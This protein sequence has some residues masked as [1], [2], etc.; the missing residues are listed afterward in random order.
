MVNSKVNFKKPNLTINDQTTHKIV[1]EASECV[2]QNW[3]QDKRLIMKL[4]LIDRP[5]GAAWRVRSTR[6]IQC[7]LFRVSR[8]PIWSHFRNQVGFRVKQNS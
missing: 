2:N 3:T 1:S 4:D 8:G 6:H 7:W 5:A